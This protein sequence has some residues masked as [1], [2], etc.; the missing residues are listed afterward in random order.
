MSEC[1]FSIVIYYWKNKRQFNVRIGY[2]GELI[3]TWVD[4]NENQT[5]S[6]R[7]KLRI[8]GPEDQLTADYVKF[9]P[10]PI[11][12]WYNDLTKDARIN[13]ENVIRS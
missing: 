13:I 12:I 9:F 7:E 5:Q 4:E 6:G 10:Y 1:N 3:D 8:N 11:Y 2:Y